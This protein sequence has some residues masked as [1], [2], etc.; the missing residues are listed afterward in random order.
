MRFSRVFGIEIVKLVFTEIRTVLEE[1]VV[2][3]LAIWATLVGVVA[4]QFLATA[5]Q[6]GNE[7]GFAVRIRGDTIDL[8]FNVRGEVAVVMVTEMK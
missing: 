2:K 7:S 5:A 6:T 1:E 8:A 3:M 4:A